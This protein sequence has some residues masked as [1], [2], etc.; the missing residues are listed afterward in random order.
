M[1]RDRW[2]R[3]CVLGEGAE[4]ANYYNRASRLKVLDTIGLRHA[5]PRADAWP[6]LML[7]V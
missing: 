1:G 5:A 6:L 2:P 4:G 7:L 3:R